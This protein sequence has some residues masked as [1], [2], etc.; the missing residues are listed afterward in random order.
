[1]I[2]KGEL[3]IVVP[4]EDVLEERSVSDRYSLKTYYPNNHTTPN[5]TVLYSVPPEQTNYWRPSRGY[6]CGLSRRVGYYRARSVPYSKSRY[7]DKS[8][9]PHCSGYRC[10]RVHSVVSVSKNGGVE[11]HRKSPVWYTRRLVLPAGS[12]SSHWNYPTP[13]SVSTGKR[14]NTAN[15][16]ASDFCQIQC[17]EYRAHVQHADRN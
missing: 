9:V 8:R 5:Q 7:G 13:D 14:C 2:K 1:M 3:H 11:R 10:S 12:V 17:A 6:R 4:G 16:S 15:C